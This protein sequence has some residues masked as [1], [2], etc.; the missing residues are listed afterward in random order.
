MTANEC[1]HSNDMWGGIPV[2]ILFGDD[3]QLPAIRDGV[4]TITDKKFLN[5]RIY[6]IVVMVW[7][8]F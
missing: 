2:V 5:I 6:K 4:T 3:Y 8:N 7:Y 1:C